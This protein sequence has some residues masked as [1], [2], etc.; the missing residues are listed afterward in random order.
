MPY[1]FRD[2]VMKLSEHLASVERVLTK[3]NEVFRILFRGLKNVCDRVK[4]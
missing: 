3:N 4:E 1:D 2:E